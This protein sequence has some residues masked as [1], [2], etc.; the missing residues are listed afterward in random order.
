[1]NGDRALTGFAEN[2]QLKKTITI[3]L[4]QDFM[5]QKS[6][7]RSKGGKGPE[8]TEEIIQISEKNLLNEHSLLHVHV[9]ALLAK[10][11]SNQD[12]KVPF[13]GASKRKSE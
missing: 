6:Q 4:Q 2:S 10:P 11:E 8:I 12:L 3:S 5:H 1:V 7:F 9:M 13:N